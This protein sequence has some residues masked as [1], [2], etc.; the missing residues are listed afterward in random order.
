ML[1]GATIGR[2]F[3]IVMVDVTSDI[4]HSLGMT[5]KRQFRRK[6]PLNREKPGFVVWPMTRISTD[7]EYTMIIYYYPY[8]SPISY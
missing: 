7:G 8:I 4:V 1:V 3:P 2:M 5:E 6:W